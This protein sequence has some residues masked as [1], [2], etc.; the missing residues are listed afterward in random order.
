M[1]IIGWLIIGLVAGWI[2]SRMAGHEK[3]MGAGPTIIVGL[4]GSV[5]GGG[6]MNLIGSYGITD[7]NIWS[8]IVSVAGAA[9]LL[10]FVNALQDFNKISEH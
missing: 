8:L 6:T 3:R 9:I 10:W 2:S 7:L 5:L 1:G 4:L